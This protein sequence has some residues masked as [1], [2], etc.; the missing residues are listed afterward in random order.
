M[1]WKDAFLRQ[2]ES[3]YA[4]FQ[5]LNRAKTPSPVCQQLHYLQMAT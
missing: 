3:D 5:Q 4:L 1:N 2:A